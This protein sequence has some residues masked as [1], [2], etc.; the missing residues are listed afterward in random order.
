MQDCAYHQ[1]L[2]WVWDEGSQLPQNLKV[3]KVWGAAAKAN[4]FYLFAA[5]DYAVQICL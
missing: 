5:L 3:S 4:H 1:Y 2:A